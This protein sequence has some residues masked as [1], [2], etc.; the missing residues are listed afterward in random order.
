MTGHLEVFRVQVLAIASSIALLLLIVELIRRGKLREQYALLWLIAAVVMLVFSLWRDL[1]D[2]LGRF[3]GVA[4]PP[5]VLFLTGLF[6][7]VLLLIHFNVAIS[8]LSEHVKTLTQ[9]VAILRH[10]LEK[11][12]KGSR[13]L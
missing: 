11:E 6:F 4:Y 8:T 1:L 5:S 13:A 9:E 7:G 2:A 3:L 10:E 12:K